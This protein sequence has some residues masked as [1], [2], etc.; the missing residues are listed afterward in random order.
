MNTNQ[1]QPMPQLETSDQEIPDW[2]YLAFG[3]MLV[4]FS[5]LEVKSDNVNSNSNNPSS[6]EIAVQ[7]NDGRFSNTSPYTSNEEIINIE[8]IM[9]VP[10]G[11]SNFNVSEND[12]S[13]LSSDLLPN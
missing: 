5:G 8:A 10:F 9:G 12:F 6:R 2:F 13:D 7:T 3:M 4:I 1:Q 11:S